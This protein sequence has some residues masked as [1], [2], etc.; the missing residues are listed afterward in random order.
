[1]AIAKRVQEKWARVVL[2][3]S[4]KMMTCAG[5]QAFRYD[6]TETVFIAVG[7]GSVRSRTGLRRERVFGSSLERLAARQTSATRG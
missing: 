3:K 6:W 2:E 7:K 5:C 1:M 4:D